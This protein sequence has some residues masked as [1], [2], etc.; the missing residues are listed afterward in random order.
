MSSMKSC[1]RIACDLSQVKF[2]PVKEHRRRETHVSE[3][4]NEN[5]MLN[6]SNALEKSKKIEIMIFLKSVVC[7]VPFNILTIH[8]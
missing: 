1:S 8:A 6:L 2:N 5:I 3:F 7:L 4:T